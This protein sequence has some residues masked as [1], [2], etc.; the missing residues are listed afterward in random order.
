MSEQD[1]KAIVAA[2]AYIKSKTENLIQ[3][4]RCEHQH[5][6]GRGVYNFMI[7]LHGKDQPETTVVFS[8]ENMEDFSADNTDYGIR[9]RYYIDFKI[10]IELIKS[11]LLQSFRVSTI[12][13]QEATDRRRGDWWN[14]RYVRVAFDNKTTTVFTVGL[15]KLKEA[16]ERTF[17]ENVVDTSSLSELKEALDLINSIINYYNVHKSLD[18]TAA[19][20]KSLSVLKAAAIYEIVDKEKKRDN[21]RPYLT[22]KINKEICEIVEFLREGVFLEVRPPEWLG[23]YVAV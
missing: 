15:K 5:D 14:D 10:Y 3:G 13:I 2:L 4:A 18:E 8:E 23:D 11:G 17:S 6:I 22:G 20:I 16:L 12:F 21:K 1:Q 7:F 19:S 9:F